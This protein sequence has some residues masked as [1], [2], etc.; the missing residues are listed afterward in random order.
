MHAQT[1]IQHK[2]KCNIFFTVYSFH[3][4]TIKCAWLKQT[5]QVSQVCTVQ[6][7]S[8]QKVAMVTNG[9]VARERIRL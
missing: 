2:I 4:M 6:K 7:V 9:G 3:K 8:V 5:D 1:D